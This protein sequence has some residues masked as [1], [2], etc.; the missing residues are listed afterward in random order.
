CLEQ[1]DLLRAL[2]ELEAKK[3]AMY[4]LENG[5]DQCMT[6]LKLALDN[7]GMWVRERWFPAEYAQATWHR[8]IPFFRLAGRV[9][10]GKEAVW[11]ELRPFND[12]QFNRDLQAMCERVAA[13]RPCLPDRRRLVFTLAGRECCPSAGQSCQAASALRASPQ[14]AA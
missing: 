13:A 8:L 2:T 5:K 3:R 7:L 6:V 10:Q 11:V 9:T 14:P 12:R 1:C 4:E